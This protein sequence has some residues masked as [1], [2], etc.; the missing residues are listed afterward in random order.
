RGLHLHRFY[1]YTIQKDQLEGSKDDASKIINFDDKSNEFHVPHLE[2][3]IA[4]LYPT[5][6][7]EQENPPIEPDIIQDRELDIRF[8]DK[9]RYDIK[10]SEMITDYI[11]LHGQMKNLAL[12]HIGRFDRDKIREFEDEYQSLLGG[13]THSHKRSNEDDLIT[14]H[15]DGDDKTGAKRDR[16]Y[17][18]LIKGRFDVTRVTYIDRKDDKDTI[19]GKAA[20]FSKKTMNL[21][22]DRGYKDTLAALDAATKITSS[23]SYKI[24]T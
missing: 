4:N 16:T 5:V 24:L 14:R 9:T 18:D 12:K 13:L 17:Y 23:Q 11:I 15:D 3:Y 22:K 8:H 20:D 7:Q 21:L 19:F 6:E 1:W 2:V 10:V